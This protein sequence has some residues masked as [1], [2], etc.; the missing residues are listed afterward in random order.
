MEEYCQKVKLYFIFLLLKTYNIHFVTG[1]ILALFYCPQTLFNRRV[2]RTLNTFN[3]L[4]FWFPV[5]I[6]PHLLRSPRSVFPESICL[7]LS[8]NNPCRLCES[9]CQIMIYFHHSSSPF[10]LIEFHDLW[11]VCTQKWAGLVTATDSNI[12][13]YYFLQHQINYDAGME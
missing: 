11:F 7:I 13:H 10:L 5:M 8:D 1:L 6:R 12:P 4:R 2:K 9:L 3:K